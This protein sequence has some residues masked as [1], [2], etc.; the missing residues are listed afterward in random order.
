MTDVLVKYTYYGDANL[1]GIVDGSDY[2]R[3]DN[4]FLTDQS[5]ATAATGWGN[6][7]FNY[8]GV[9]N[10]SDYTLIDNAF[11]SQ[12]AS[13]AAALAANGVPTITAEVAA[14]VIRASYPF[15]RSNVATSINAAG[16]LDIDDM[17]D[18]WSSER[19][20]GKSVK[21]R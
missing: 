4:A 21:H 18:S 7:D 5:N 14:P 11:N 9:T 10:G 12:G 19:R 16:G 13:L 2:S 1:D 15:A 17:L 20:A 6:G 8:D 3:I